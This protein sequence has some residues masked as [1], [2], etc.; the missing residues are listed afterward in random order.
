MAYKT[1]TTMDD[2]LQIHLFVT[3]SAQI[4]NVPGQIVLQR[5]GLLLSFQLLESSGEVIKIDIIPTN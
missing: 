4:N 1:D 3:K 5:T 2:K